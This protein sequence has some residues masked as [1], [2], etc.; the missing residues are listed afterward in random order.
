MQKIIFN[1]KFGLTG[2]A[3][4]HTKT[5]TRR[6]IN[7]KYSS[8]II[9]ESKYLGVLGDEKEYVRIIP[10]YKMGEVLAV[11][12]SYEVL[13]Y[14]PDALDRDPKDLGIRGFMKHSAGWNNKM[15]VRADAC[16][17]HVKITGIRVER[18]QDISD[19]DCLKE[20]VYRL[21]SANGNG[22]VVYSFVGA[23]DKK[24]IGLY[25]TPRDAFSVLIDRVSGKGTWNTNPLVFAYKFELVQIL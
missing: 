7:G 23:S 12:Q 8:I 14:A 1:D 20:G 25:D 5:M 6:F 4:S 21:N 10:K 11:A 19:E 17:S 22:G 3:L 18:L 2:A 15:F 16:K 13:R 24:N 9:S